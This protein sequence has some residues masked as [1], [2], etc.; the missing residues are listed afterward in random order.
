LPRRRDVPATIAKGALLLQME[1]DLKPRPIAAAFAAL[2][3]AAMIGGMT[4]QA[5]AFTACQVTDTGGV[6]DKGFN[7]TA[8]KGVQ[9]AQTEMGIEGKLLESSAETDYA[10]NINSFISDNCDLI[11]TVGF[12]LGDATKAAA[13]ANPD[14]KFS[15]VDFAYDPVI[16]NVL[17][18]VFA[19]D[20]A[21]FLAGYLAAGVSKS[22]IVGTFGG[23]NIPP[24][25]IFMDGFVRGV[26]YYN[27]QK[28]AEVKV[29][30]WDAE[31]K[32]GLFT[33]NFDSLDDGRSFA[34]NLYDE[35]ADIVM[36]V[37]GPVGLGSA[38]LAS[39]L[40]TDKLKII[41]VDVDQYLTDPEHQ[42]VY[43]TSVEKKMD[44]T[45]M[46][47]IK[48]AQDGSFEGGV[49]VGTLDNGGVGLAPF[50][51][52]DSAVPA[53][54]KSELDTIRQGIIDGSISVKG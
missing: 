25:S 30:G 34:Q 54:L 52:L 10:P 33:N 45:V 22:G 48:M 6:D 8:W 46:Q 47:A 20:E 19:T 3:T 21:A 42:G 23:I 11:V 2:A 39:E 40:G 53:E 35:G 1:G 9:D 36:P 28:G 32:E 16:P 24:V 17:G 41:G 29:L 7:Q 15:I 38:A 31:T 12:L 51:D 26:D 27:E 43:L 37:A 13:E 4:T 50:H 14:Q 18:Q 44:A 5:A 49:V